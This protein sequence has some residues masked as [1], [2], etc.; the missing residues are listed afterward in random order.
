[1]L[2]FGQV[3]AALQVNIF[4]TVTI[5]YLLFIIEHKTWPKRKKEITGMK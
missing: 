1:M 2:A 4:L 5:D 3:A